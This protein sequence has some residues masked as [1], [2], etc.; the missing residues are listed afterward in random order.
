MQSVETGAVRGQDLLN[1]K[2][3]SV[4]LCHRA[5][6]RHMST[7]RIWISRH[8]FNGLLTTCT[9][10]CALAQ[11]CLLHRGFKFDP[12]SPTLMDPRVPRAAQALTWIGA[13]SESS[14][15]ADQQRCE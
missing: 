9:R 10:A 5:M 8:A 13:R 7:C 4:R 14:T 12:L 11:G 15:V 3:E 6:K 1:R 2:T